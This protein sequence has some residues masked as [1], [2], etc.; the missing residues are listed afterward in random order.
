MTKSKKLILPVGIIALT[1]IV[2]Q[3]IANNP[4]SS[5]RRGASSA[6]QM[7]VNVEQLKPQAYQVVV[8]SFGTVRPRTQSALYAQVSGQITKV[9]PHFREGGFFEQGEVLVTLDNRDYLAEQKIAQSN[10]LSAQQSL[11]EEQAKVERATADWA[12]LGNGEQPS[13]LVLRKPQ[14]AAAQASLLSAQAQLEKAKLALE[15]SEI[16]APYAGRILQQNVDLGQW[17]SSN[18]QLAELYASDYVEVRLP[19]KN[20]DLALMTLPVEFK[21]SVMNGDANVTFTSSLLRDTHWQGQLI[22][23]E[24]AIDTAAQQL[25]VVAQINDPYGYEQ[26]AQGSVKIGEYLQAKINGKLLPNVIVIPNSAIYQG[27]YV[28]VVE[29]G[30]LKRREITI[31]WQNGNDAIIDSGLAFDDL[32]VTTSL[33][34]V[35][36]GTRVSILGEH[37]DKG[38]VEKKKRGKAKPKGSDKAAK[39]VNS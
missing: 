20:N 39:G 15:R 1:I 18:T 23:T 16:K 35:S 9:N 2:T 29:Q 30:V 13:D 24:S 5:E 33:G 38:S 26:S 28:Y 27:S 32:L 12:R 4:P 21:G 19:I 25:Y 14:L 36:S 3:F 7:S 22:R 31:R 10:V 8:E 11:L 34:Q 37:Q 6:P 17:V